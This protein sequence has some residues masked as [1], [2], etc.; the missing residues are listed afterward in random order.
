MLVNT[1]AGVFEG[2]ATAMIYDLF[3]K[4]TN[5]GGVSVRQLPGTS[6]YLF[7]LQNIPTTPKTVYFVDLHLSDPLGKTVSTN[8]YWLTT[9]DYQSLR[10][11]AQAK[12]AAAATLTRPGERWQAT[13]TLVSATGQ[14]VAFWIRLQVLGS[15]SGERILPVFYEDNYFSLVPGKRRDI[16]IDFAAADVPP[17]ETPQIWI[18]GWNVARSQV[19]LTQQA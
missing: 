5:G 13:V 10:Q 19:K 17:G 7:S 8:L 2:T 16:I 15:G 3:G 18:E 4:A 11:L 1:S 6:Q 12:I 14:P 9:G